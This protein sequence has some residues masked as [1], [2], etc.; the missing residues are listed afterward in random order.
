MPIRTRKIDKQQ[1]LM[2]QRQERQRY[3]HTQR[4]RDF[5]ARLALDTKLVEMAGLERAKRVKEAEAKKILNH[6]EKNKA[7]AEKDKADRQKIPTV[8]GMMIPLPLIPPPP[9]LG[10]TKPHGWIPPPKA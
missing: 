4:A 10:S 1:R 2:E 9:A 8:K 5:Q 7:R 6:K 3:L